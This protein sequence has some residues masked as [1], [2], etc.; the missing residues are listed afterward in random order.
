MFCV[1][2]TFVNFVS[3]DSITKKKIVI[4]VVGVIS[5]MLM[6]TQ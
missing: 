5:E 4:S 1:N 6:S 2:F 3:G